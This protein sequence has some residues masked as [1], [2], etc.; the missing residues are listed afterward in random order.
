MH[1]L[2]FVI[3][4]KN[5]TYPTFGKLRISDRLILEFLVS[6][7]KETLSGAEPSITMAYVAIEDEDWPRN[8]YSIIDLFT[9][10]LA[11]IGDI[12][13]TYRNPIG[14]DIPSLNELSKIRITYADYK[15]H[16]IHAS[17]DY[18]KP[19]LTAKEQYLKIEDDR[20]IILNCYLGLALRYY[21]YALQ[22]YHREPRRIDEVTIDL[23][24]A[25]EALFSTGIYFTK[26]LKYRLSNFIT[27]D[28]SE[29]AKIAKLISN[30]YDYRSDLM[31]GRLTKRK[32][33]LNEI[34]AVKQYIKRAI[35]KTL[36]LRLY[37]KKQLIK[38]IGEN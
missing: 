6:P 3:N 1:Q 38:Y 14:T 16:K 26:N 8:A 19:I 29:K 33:T 21:Y 30:F 23:S 12:S 9:L 32:I 4:F 11:L 37:D 36:F 13:A 5:I 34:I 28:Q 2:E 18:E 7:E 27:Q 22:S 25:A 10:T 35:I 31:H 20:D 24:I 17:P 15:M